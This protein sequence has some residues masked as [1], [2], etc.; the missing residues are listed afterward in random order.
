VAVFSAGTA[1]AVITPP[2]GLD[3]SG[4]SFGPS[5]GVHDDLYAKVLMINDGTGPV[6]LIAADLIGL[7]TGYADSFRRETAGKLNT[8]PERVIFS[9]SHTHSGPGAM[10]LRRWGSVDQG[11]L[12]SALQ[13]IMDAAERA[14]NR[15]EPCRAGSGSGTVQGICDN[16]RDDR[17]K[18]VD[19]S[20]PVIRIDRQ[21]GT[22]LAVLFSYS[23][24]PVAAH[25]DR[26]LI[27]ADYPGFARRFL[28]EQYKEADGL[29]MLGPCGDVNPVEFHRLELA[30]RYGKM[31]GREAAAVCASLSTR[32]DVTVTVKTERVS[33]PVKDLPSARDLE[34]EK[35]IR[36]R[37]AN[38]YG[39]R[40]LIHK[41]EDALVKAEWAR[42]A[43]E[44]VTAGNQQ[45]HLEMEM[46]VLAIG[47]TAVVTLP[48]ELFTE[49]GMNIKSRSPFRTTIISEL[50]NGSLCYIP[51]ASAF[52]RGGYETEFSAKVYGLYM[53]TRE[54]QRIVE[55][56][57]WKLLAEAAE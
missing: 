56:T 36:S 12:A 18:M 54:A 21:D 43:L 20:L 8:S 14:L 46:G 28:E 4:W 3:L 6:V 41:R 40:G 52:D 16:R 11:Y 30:G 5:K 55:E 33:L 26:N 15:A 45:S 9:C 2:V 42:E 23:C 22:P 51:T 27:S 49:I 53:L 13:K 37:E 24:H 38:D 47:D 35:E 1:S 50:T 10:K 29:F 25:N 39:T 32:E 17:I 34:L 57:A 7:G 48:G 31:I 19:E 44:V